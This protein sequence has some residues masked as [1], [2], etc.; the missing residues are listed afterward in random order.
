MVYRKGE[1]HLSTLDRFYP[2]HVAILIHRE[3]PRERFAFYGELDAFY[4]SMNEAPRFN[5]IG[6]G[7][8]EHIIYGFKTEEAAQAFQDRFGGFRIEPTDK[9]RRQVEERL[10]AERAAPSE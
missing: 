7:Q 4:R 3:S 5:C 8:T 10:R 6:R 2:F 1:F 9:A